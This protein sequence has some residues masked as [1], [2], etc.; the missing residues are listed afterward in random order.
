VSLRW[1]IVLLIWA[2][3]IAS[4]L[5]CPYDLHGVS[6]CSAISQ[7]GQTLSFYLAAPG[8]VL[9]SW[10]SSFVQDDPR[11][12]ASFTAHAIGA[13]SWLLLLSAL[14]LFVPGWLGKLFLPTRRRP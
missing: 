13:I 1:L 12:G 7:F 9:G 6:T 10:L 4:L 2:V 11:A 5:A 8:L 3:P 14:V